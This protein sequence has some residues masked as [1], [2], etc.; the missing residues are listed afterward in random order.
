MLEKAAILFSGGKDSI[1]SLQ[2]AQKYVPIDLIVSLTSTQGDTQF[3][4]GPEVEK[5]LRESQLQ[6][7]GIEN[8]TLIL[9]AGQ[10]YLRNFS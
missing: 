3:H 4:A 1:Y 5:A 9:S 8:E 10:G 6:L 2:A 7:L